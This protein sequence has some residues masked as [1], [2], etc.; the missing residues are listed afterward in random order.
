MG[1]LLCST[2]L[3]AGPDRCEYYGI[4]IWMVVVMPS[5]EDMRPFKRSHLLS[6]RNVA[7]SAKDGTAVLFFFV[8]SGLEF[9]G[10]YT[11]F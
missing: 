7:H 4:P 11:R 2:I 6:D 3:V 1:L 10:G 5:Q 8:E 9:S